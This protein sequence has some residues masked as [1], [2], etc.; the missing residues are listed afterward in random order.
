MH[1]SITHAQLT[2]MHAAIMHTHA[3]IMHVNIMNM[4]T[5]IMHTTIMHATIY[6]YHHY[7]CHYYACHHGVY[8]AKNISDKILASSDHISA[9]SQPGS[10]PAS[11]VIILLVRDILTDILRVLQI[12]MQCTCMVF[13]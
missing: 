5:A 6:A 10:M 12:L 9:F 7:T 8:V 11:R 3:T 4:H 2:I 13:K 1:T